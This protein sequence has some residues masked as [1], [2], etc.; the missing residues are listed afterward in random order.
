[1][2]HVRALSGAIVAAF[3]RWNYTGNMSHCNAHKDRLIARNIP[4]R[5]LRQRLSV[6]FKWSPARFTLRMKPILYFAPSKKKREKS[7]KKALRFRIS[8]HCSAAL[9]NNSFINITRN[10]IRNS[11]TQRIVNYIWKRQCWGNKE[12]KNILPEFARFNVIM[13]RR[14]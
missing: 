5:A 10:I 7:R 12:M 6:R 9:R 4:T 1:V 3:A 8:G 11:E 13:Y 14:Q 2:T